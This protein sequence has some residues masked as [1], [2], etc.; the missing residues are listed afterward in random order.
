M[1][2]IIYLM[3]VFILVSS[4]LAGTKLTDVEQINTAFQGKTIPEPLASLFGNA[5]INL[6]FKLNS[7]QELVVGLVTENKQF[8]SLKM[9]GVPEPDLNIFTSE[10]TVKEIESSPNP[11]EAL[12]NAFNEGKITYKAVGITNKIKFV[13]L[14]LFLKIGDAF[15]GDST[16]EAKEVVK[17]ETSTEKNKEKKEAETVIPEVEEPAVN[18]SPT[19]EENLSET[20]DANETVSE[21]VTEENDHKRYTVELVNGGFGI[22]EPL[23]I[24]VGDMVEWVN[25]RSGTFKKAMVLGVHNCAKL[26][27]KMYEPGA[28]FNWTFDKA[29]T[30]LIVDG[31]YTTQTMKVIVE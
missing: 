28:S 15:G 29:E 22:A 24:K 7:N 21:Q 14:S 2:K 27:S 11:P 25:V 12:K 8:Q 1:K 31:I 6:H 26:K 19:L 10:A 3:M 20:T 18:T 4:V 23:R 9:G 5:N 17:N 16:E 13:F 30:C